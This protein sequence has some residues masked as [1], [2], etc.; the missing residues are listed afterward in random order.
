M[1]STLEQIIG[2][3]LAALREGKGWNLV[4]MGEALGEPLGQEWSRQ[5]V[6]LAEKG[7]RSFAAPDLVGLAAALGVTV[8]DLLSTN[9][10]V[11]VGKAAM[12]PERILTLTEGDADADTRL[13]YQIFHTAGEVKNSMRLSDNLYWRL[14]KDVRHAA[15]V[16]A[17]LRKEI[18]K[19]LDTETRHV[20]REVRK[21][22]AS[23]GREEPT[24][25]ALQD[26]LEAYVTP[27]LQTARDA[28]EGIGDGEGN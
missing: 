8:N 25:Q 13:Y 16:N 12:T 6:W 28:L 18:A 27:A 17:D 15:L 26:A 3:N 9:E 4:K 24:G 5:A 11:T 1:E 20:L 23:D 10:T 21:I 19:D 2:R 22:Y 7:K 14:I